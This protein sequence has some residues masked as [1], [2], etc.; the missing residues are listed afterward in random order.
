M[1][2]AL[3]V[4]LFFFFFFSSFDSTQIFFLIPLCPGT[5]TTNPAVVGRGHKMATPV[6]ARAVRAASGQWKTRCS[7]YLLRGGGTCAGWNRRLSVEV[8]KR[9]KKKKG[10]RIVPNFI[11]DCLCSAGCIGGSGHSWAL[12]DLGVLG[13][14][15]PYRLLAVPP[16]L[17]NRLKG[18]GQRRCAEGDKKVPA[19][20]S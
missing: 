6:F 18:L 12:A 10:Q 19:N 5:F 11:W 7:I 14:P 16:Y 15:L 4:P 20:L 8:N 13:F 9:K 3:T 17:E 2:V 1:K